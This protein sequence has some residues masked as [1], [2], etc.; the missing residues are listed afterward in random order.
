MSRRHIRVLLTVQKLQLWDSG[1]VIR[2]YPI[3]TSAYGA[4]EL[5]GSKRT[6]RGQHE[7]AEK[8]GH[9]QSANAVFVSRKATGEVCT[10]DVLQSQPDRDWILSR[11][12]RLRGLEDGR[13]IGGSVDTES[14]YVYIHGTPYEDD[15]GQP[16]SDGCIRMRN[17][18]VIELFE[19][20]DEGT[21]VEII[22]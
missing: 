2:E 19:L 15:I 10:P 3:S 6:P 8:I 7:I 17:S 20:V 13:N 12:L 18:D 11:I 5:Q 1:W 16:A 21:P 4:G 9:G 14:R 22:E